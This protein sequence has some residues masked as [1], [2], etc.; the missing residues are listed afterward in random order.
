MDHLCMRVDPFDEEAIVD[1]LKAN[2]VRV[3]DVGMRYGA[4]GDGPSMYLYDPEGNMV[5]LKGP[6][7][8]PPELEPDRS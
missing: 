2:G 6:P 7:V 1:Y 4:Q 3:G 8:T 5:E